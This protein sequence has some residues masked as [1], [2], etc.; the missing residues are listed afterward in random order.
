MTR[1]LWL[2][3]ETV[4]KERK[5]VEKNAKFAAKKAKAAAT[6]TSQ[7]PSKNKEKKIRSEISAEVQLPEYVEETP[8]GQKK[9]KSV[10]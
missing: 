6:P 7:E 10:L 2:T 8:E 1:P 4:E 9:S 5:Q 3:P